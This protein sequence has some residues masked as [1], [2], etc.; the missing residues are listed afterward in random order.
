MLRFSTWTPMNLWS[1]SAWTHKKHS[2]SHQPAPID[3]TMTKKKLSIVTTAFNSGEY[4]KRTIDSVLNQNTSQFEYEYLIGDDASTDD[5]VAVVKRFMHE[6]PKG[7]NITLI[8]NSNNQ[9]VVRNF[10]GLLAKSTGDYV[11]FCDS[12]DIWCDENK[13]DK[14]FL[15]MENETEAV[16]SYHA[17]SALYDFTRVQNSPTQTLLTPHTSTLMIRNGLID[18]PWPLVNEMTRMNDQLLRLL[19]KQKGAFLPLRNILPNVRVVRQSSVFAS[20][21]SELQRKRSSLEN[22]TFIYNYYRDT[23]LASELRRKTSRFQSA[24]NWLEFQNKSSFAKLLSNVKFDLES[25]QVLR[26]ASITLRRHLAKLYQY[27]SQR[28]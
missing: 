7:S 16:L 15:A 10:F 26:K 5:T 13:L 2:K 23:E 28:K 17:T 4:I 18:I 19:L 27:V 24:I 6:H 11:A 25:G 22:W 8:Q 3:A 14:Q 20:P 12:D 21:R 9:G 1:T